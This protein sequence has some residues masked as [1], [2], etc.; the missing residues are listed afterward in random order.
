MLTEERF[1]IILKELEEKNVVT[2]KEI[3]N[4]LNSSEATTRR[5][6]S[7]L[8]KQ[9]KLVKVHGGA[10]KT[11]NNY[12]INEEDNMT[13]KQLYKEEKNLI[14]KKAV[15][16]IKED[17]FIYIDAGTS[18]YELVKEMAGISN[19]EKIGIVT[20]ALHHGL[21]LNSFGFKVY[22]LGGEI[23][24]STG[25]IVGEEA[26]DSLNKYNFTKGFFGANGV[27]ITTGFSTY[28]TKE[29]LIKSKAIEKCKEAYILVDN[30]KFNKIAPVTFKHLC[31]CSIITNNLTDMTFKEKTNILEA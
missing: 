16:L 21:L 5:D 27:N 4:I 25:A 6:F 15:T 7:A 17:D 12:I 23:K 11:N 28:D 22:I 10:K 18:T 13:K 14:A 24:S 1:E 8:E 29:A 19:K 3:T 31:G 9:G 20:N 2:V 30:S 26:I